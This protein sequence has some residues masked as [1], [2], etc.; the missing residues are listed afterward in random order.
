MSFAYKLCL[1]A[2]LLPITYEGLEHIPKENCI[3]IANHQSS[4]DIV[5][6]GSLMGSR[7]HVWLA[8]D[9]LWKYSFFP[10]LL[11]CF[12]IPVSFSALN[13]SAVA[14]QIGVV[15]KAR[16]KLEAGSSVILFPEAGRYVDGT[17]HP[18][19]SG[20]A[21]LAFLTRKPVVPVFMHGVGHVMPPGATFPQRRAPITVI[22]GEP[23]VYQEG[24]TIEAF[25]LRVFQWYCAMNAAFYEKVDT[26]KQELKL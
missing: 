4:L 2:S 12:A 26:Q 24:E 5:L 8:K 25:K 16:Q 7:P 14:G 17:I 15:A 22:V 10:K 18:F 9:E 20:F 11:N 1:Y 23:F 19:R 6:V 13:A 3:F 21:A